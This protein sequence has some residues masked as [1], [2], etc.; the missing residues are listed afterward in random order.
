MEWGLERGC[1][2]GP[3]PCI[4]VNGRMGEMGRIGCECGSGHVPVCGAALC[5]G[6]DDVGARRSVFVPG[7]THEDVKCRLQLA[8]SAFGS[9][10][11]ARFSGSPSP[12]P[13]RRDRQPGLFP[14]RSGALARNDYDMTYPICQDYLIGSV[15]LGG[16]AGCRT[17]RRPV[18]KP[19]L[20]PGFA[21]A[22]H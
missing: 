6:S 11:S 2:D 22:V 5:R 3:G 7:A 18:R 8:Y 20:L 17:A 9:E 16:F 21:C 19:G 4:E 13:I 10:R 1:R 14:F 12:I 15:M